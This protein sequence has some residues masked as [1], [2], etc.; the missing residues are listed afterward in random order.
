[1]KLQALY[2]IC[3]QRQWLLMLGCCTLM[4]LFFITRAQ[5]SVLDTLPPRDVFSYNNDV[6]YIDPSIGQFEAAAI[7]LS[8]SISAIFGV[9]GLK[10]YAYAMYPKSHPAGKSL[11]FNT[12]WQKEL[13]RIEEEVIALNKPALRSTT[14]ENYYLYIAWQLDAAGKIAEA[15]VRCKLPTAPESECG[16]SESLLEL[17]ENISQTFH[18][19]FVSTYNSTL[20]P[21]KA[22]A[23]AMAAIKE[24]VKGMEESSFEEFEG[25]PLPD[26][27]E[28]VC[29]PAGSVFITP[30]RQLIRISEAICPFFNFGEIPSF[31]K[32]CLVNFTTASGI[33]YSS[34]LVHYTPKEVKSL[35]PLAKGCGDTFW[36]YVKNDETDKYRDSDGKLTNWGD[37]KTVAHKKDLLEVG[38]FKSYTTTG[39][40]AVTIKG[41]EN[42]V[43]VT[44]TFNVDLPSNEDIE[45]PYS[46][47]S[48]II[49][50]GTS[51]ICTFCDKNSPGAHYYDKAKKAGMTPEQFLLLCENAR[52]LNLLSKK[53]NIKVD[54]SVD[55]DYW[56]DI[57]QEY[58]QTP[59]GLHEGDTPEERLKKIYAFII[60]YKENVEYLKK[61]EEEDI[62]NLSR[63]FIDPD[64]IAILSCADRMELLRILCSEGPKKLK[65]SHTIAY[66]KIEDTI[67]RLLRD[68]AVDKKCFLEALIAD[69]NTFCTLMEGF[70]DNGVLSFLIGDGNN[71]RFIELLLNLY[72][73]VLNSYSQSALRA[74]VR[75]DRVIQVGFS[76]YVAKASSCAP[77]H[78]D[79]DF[80]CNGNI[81][82]GWNSISLGDSLL[83]SAYS[84]AVVTS[85][86]RETSPFTFG[87]F[88]LV[89]VYNYGG[90]YPVLNS[91]PKNIPI[92]AFI[93]PYLAQVN[94]NENAGE[95]IQ[96][97]LAAIGA[98]FTAGTVVAA[99][100]VATAEAYA[101][102]ALEAVAT[103]G[104]FVSL[105]R[106]AIIG[107]FPTSNQGIAFLNKLDN[108][109]IA[110]SVAS[111]KGF[112]VAKARE[113]VD[114]LEEGLRLANRLS[115]MYNNLRTAVNSLRTALRLAG[116]S[117]DAEFII[118]VKAAFVA[119]GKTADDV[120]ANNY[121][122]NFKRLIGKNNVLSLPHLSDDF[123]RI[124]ETCSLKVKKFLEDAVSDWD[125][126]VSFSKFVEDIKARP[127]LL[128]DMAGNGGM[129]DA[130]KALSD[131]DANV[132]RNTTVLNWFSRNFEDASG[133]ADD[134]RAAITNKNI[135][136]IITDPQGR[137]SF[138]VSRPGQANEVVSIHRTV[139]G[140]FQIIKY[141]PAYNPN[142]N[143]A[144][145][146]PLSP[147]GLV[148][149][150]SGTIYLHPLNQG[151]TI[152]ITMTGRRGGDFSNADQAMKRLF[153]TYT[154]P[155][156]YTWHHM[157]DFDPQTGTCTM[158][159]VQSSA[160]QGTGVT[161]MQHSGSVAQWKS[162]YIS[163]ANAPNNLFYEN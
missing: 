107:L 63:I 20:I 75:T 4:T 100:E 109:F 90:N 86:T 145:P 124:Y 35:G 93:L 142:L 5:A 32:G 115:P 149:D 84:E 1:M 55:I 69:K 116:I 112:N 147:N 71:K 88:D 159:L 22:G 160:H 123:L 51:P 6:G 117:L 46:G 27:C 43:F 15:R 50:P 41:L 158:Q 21:G 161:G 44:Y 133:L 67:L 105:N 64:L 76:P 101:I 92:P 126:P 79:A 47:G 143:P 122:E 77:I 96:W 89:M 130:W 23:T 131:L 137:L 153:P 104:D 127:S 12:L 132:R 58:Y 128:D 129:L 18:S 49:P 70:I 74:L 25:P 110:I 156:G 162:Y 97:V 94:Q 95:A 148:P 11:S 37:D 29:Y 134:L 13:S 31:P 33:K 28:Q 8:N 139:N 68:V 136:E 65:G 10:V 108:V 57:M 150:Y 60:Y 53:W 16:A 78:L 38:R 52:T 113:A 140:D 82:S 119:V 152:R 102:A 157:D 141:T 118:R 40:G 34:I 17:E 66:D 2:H 120:T 61:I 24:M 54:K 121:L 111:M 138:V 135:T 48:L 83:T 163:S 80:D 45:G 7:E 14:T 9:F 3:H 106:R 87:A 42:G 85:C 30:S 36:A 103:L 151:Q 73:E 125:D 155:T 91:L 56:V 146:V 39:A 72:F 26:S 81:V 154:K 62:K 98:Y 144:I 114:E 19:A 59:R 99:I